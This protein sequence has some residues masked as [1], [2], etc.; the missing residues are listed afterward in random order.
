MMFRLVHITTAVAAMDITAGDHDLHW[1]RRS[2][3]SVG[4]KY[5]P[6]PMNRIDSVDDGRRQSDGVRIHDYTPS[7]TDLGP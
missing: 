7:M 6:C 1:R 5:L 2:S 4:S 3:H